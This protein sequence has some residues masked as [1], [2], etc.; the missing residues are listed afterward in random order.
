MTSS[1][2]PI[3]HFERK[4]MIDSSGYVWNNDKQEKKTASVNPNG[5]LMV[6]LKMNGRYEQV[7]VHR[8]VA[9]H[10]IPNPYGHTIV[11][12]KDGIK[13]N[14]WKDN[15]EWTDHVGNAQ[16]ALETGLRSGYMSRIEKDELVQ[17]VLSGELIRNIALETGRREE[18]LSGMLRR[19]TDT[20]GLREAWDTEMKRRRRD[21]AIRNLEPINSRNTNRS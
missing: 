20:F 2:V 21:V 12:H 18:S 7:S 13:A 3:A 9:L 4:Y 11:N 10:F 19:H 16:H 8:L 1:R 15:L 14:C 17:R 6:Q 5:Y